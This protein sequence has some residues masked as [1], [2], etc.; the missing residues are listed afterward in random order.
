[1]FTDWPI[2]RQL[3]RLHHYNP[4]F[5]FHFYFLKK[6]S[7]ISKI[8]S[9]VINIML[10]VMLIYL[11]AEISLFWVFYITLAYKFSFII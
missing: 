5:F 3:S 2:S 8:L 7:D 11:K 1:M 9:A 6:R 10:K 4:D